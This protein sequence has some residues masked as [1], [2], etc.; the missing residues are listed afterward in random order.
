MVINAS[1]MF[2]K[3]LTEETIASY[4]LNNRKIAYAKTYSYVEG[5]DLLFRLKDFLKSLQTVPSKSANAC[6][7][8]PIQYKKGL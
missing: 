2:I 7:L 8:H 6:S 3:M 1:N 5:K 4:N